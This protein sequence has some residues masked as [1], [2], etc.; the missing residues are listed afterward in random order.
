VAVLSLAG[1]LT[2]G[3]DCQ[4]VKG[5]LDDLLQQGKLRVIF[6]LSDL[7]YIDSAGVGMVVTCFH[8]LKQCG[9]TL[10]LAGATGT[11]KAILKMVNIHQ[12]IQFFPTVEAAAALNDTLLELLP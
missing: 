9:G 8:K 4:Q 7:S 10:R 12:V 2:V 1:R 6:D 11:V 3:R 5:Q